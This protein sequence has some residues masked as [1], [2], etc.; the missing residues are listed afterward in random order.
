MRVNV[1]KRYTIV[2]PG[3][4][5]ALGYRP[6]LAQALAYQVA[7]TQAVPDEGGWARDARRDLLHREHAIRQRGLRGH[8]L[9]Q[10]GR[11]H[12]GGGPVEGLKLLPG[13]S[14]GD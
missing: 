6:V 14:L 8:E 7:T 2:K 1:P 3:R 5:V 13:E 10:D 11:L 9:Q 4:Q 12:H